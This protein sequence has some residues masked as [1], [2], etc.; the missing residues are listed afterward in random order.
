MFDSWEPIHWIALA[1]G[2][3]IV[4]L[5]R[6]SMC[7]A[8]VHGTRIQQVSPFFVSV[9]TDAFQTCGSKLLHRTVSR[10][11]SLTPM[12]GSSTLLGRFELNNKKLIMSA[13]SI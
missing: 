11:V 3:N 12:S 10:T 4:Y 9:L 13:F 5:L 2:V 7:F 8:Y 1:I 6:I